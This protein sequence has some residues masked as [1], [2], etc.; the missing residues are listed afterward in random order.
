MKKLDDFAQGGSRL[1]EGREPV[2]THSAYGRWVNEVTRWLNKIAPGTGLAAEWVSLGTSEL[3]SSRGYAIGTV[4]W[5][6][7]NST[8][9]RRL[10]WLSKLPQRLSALLSQDK[11]SEKVQPKPL[12]NLKVFLV[13][14]HNDKVKEMAARFIEQLGLKAIILHEQPNSGRTIIE[15]FIDFSDVGYAVVILTADDLA[16]PNNDKSSA[17][18][19]RARQNVIFE[20]GYFIGKLNRER[21]CALY[22]EGVEIPSD[23]HGVLFVKLDNE[24]VWKFKLAKEMKAVGLPIDLNKM[25]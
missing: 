12:D 8:V 3:V 21:V 24:G 18:Q 16:K 10:L 11:E 1:L 7:F 15:K 25:S 13:H 23:Y 4:A 5:H 22:Q 17:L 14:G 20:L 19:S 6:N 2:E 9:Q